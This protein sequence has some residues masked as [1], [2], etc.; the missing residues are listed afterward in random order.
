MSVISAL[1]RHL[2]ALTDKS[3]AS[4][5]VDFSR[6]RHR[7]CQ[8]PLP[9]ADSA[10]VPLPSVD[11]TVIVLQT[12]GASTPRCW[13]GSGLPRCWA[14]CCLHPFLSAGIWC[15]LLSLPQGIILLA[16]YGVRPLVMGTRSTNRRL[17]GMGAVLYPLVLW[18]LT[19]VLAAYLARDDVFE[20]AGIISAAVAAGVVVY[21]ANSIRHLNKASSGLR[22]PRNERLKKALT[23]SQPL[24]EAASCGTHEADLQT[25]RF[26]QWLI[27]LGL[28]PKTDFS[29]HEL[30]P[31]FSQRALKIQLFEV[32]TDLALY[33]YTCCPNFHGYLSRAQRNCI[34]KTMI[35]EAMGYVFEVAYP[36]QSPNLP[37]C[38]LLTLRNQGAGSG[39]PSQAISMS[40]IGILT[41]GIIL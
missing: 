5:S 23:K 26:V 31:K 1:L 18:V 32:V 20:P 8:G 27:E 38:L 25:L 14:D 15:I 28:T 33:Q 30:P 41:R 37:A 17:T 4:R 19:A 7:A 11:G 13:A 34:E 39:N 40:P 22:I 6:C 36:R 2:K 10:S 29:Y 16:G 21:I 3:P 9:Q 24:S 12:E 35:K